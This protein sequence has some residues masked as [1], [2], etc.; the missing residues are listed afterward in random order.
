MGALDL[1][2]SAQAARRGVIAASRPERISLEGFTYRRIFN[3]EDFADLGELRRQVYLNAYSFNE[4]DDQPVYDHFD[5]EDAT[6]NFGIYYYDKMVSAIRINLVGA[7]YPLTPSQ[8]WFQEVWDPLI[9]QGMRFV[10]P[11]RFVVNGAFS[12]EH[13]IL[14]FLTLRIAHMATAHYQ[15]DYCAA[16][17]SVSH[18]G[19]YRRIF[20][21]TRL[22]G[23]RKFDAYNKKFVMM[24]GPLHSLPDIEARFPIFEHT[25]TERRMLFEPAA[26]GLYQLSV[27]PRMVV[28][29][30]V[31]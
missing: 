10:D 29:R 23:P 31:A 11:N 18:E 20:K 30:Q 26:N 12:D 24:G 15:T 14:P 17:V 13:P 3:D 19:F 25:D 27:V 4:P 1:F 16:F 7:D 9:A 22:A 28:R 5:Y 21:A 8:R 2:N 6:Q